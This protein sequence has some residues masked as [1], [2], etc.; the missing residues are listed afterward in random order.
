MN[1]TCLLNR[2]RDISLRSSKSLIS[3]INAAASA[4][5]SLNGS[6]CRLMTVNGFKKRS[7][8]CIHAVF[9]LLLLFCCSEDIFLFTPANI[10]SFFP[11]CFG[12]NATETW[13]NQC[14]LFS[15]NEFMDLVFTWKRRAK[16][17]VGAFCCIPGSYSTCRSRRLSHWKRKNSITVFEAAQAHW[18]KWQ[19]WP[20]HVNT[21]ITFCDHTMQQYW[22]DMSM[23]LININESIKY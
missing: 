12:E 22:V 19:T 3:Q 2:C 20:S 13:C 9:L 5:F 7:L 1:T 10:C 8:L 21:I 6:P 11:R 17:T 15:P 16:Q 4:Y 18:Y 14:A 23:S